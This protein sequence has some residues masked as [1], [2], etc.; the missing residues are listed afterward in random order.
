MK[1]LVI[2]LGIACISASATAQSNQPS[3]RIGNIEIIIRKQE[4]DTTMQVNILDGNDKPDAGS[5]KSD[6]QS[7]PQPQVKPKFKQYQKSS[8]L[9]G[10][11]LMIPDNNNDYYT[12]LGGNSFNF[13]FGGMKRYHL[14]RR[15]ALGWSCNYS[16]YNYKL[17]D[18]NEEEIF[19]REVLQDKIFEHDISK[20]V[21]RSHNVAFGTFAR[22][23]L[24]TRGDKLYVDLGAQGDFA[25]FR[26]YMIK[27][28]NGGK[29]YWEND[30]AFN[31]FSAS[32]VA[33][34]GLKS[35]AFFFRYRFTDNFN[36]TVLPKDLPPIT[37][38]IVW[39][40]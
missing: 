23:Y 25:P 31:A 20:Q 9:G 5:S 35:H 15:F 6:V 8:V 28:T 14:S 34:I 7:Q 19:K 17:N 3:V 2:I 13:D 10:I 26:K 40:D 4:Q 1:K 24:T 16:F 38:G 11:G 36:K 12:T 29:N 37:F 18:I 21:F 33:R 27:F 32:A 39:F 22:Y 30:H